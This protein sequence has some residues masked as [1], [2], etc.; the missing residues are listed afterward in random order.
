MSSRHGNISSYRVKKSILHLI[1]HCMK[2]F[3]S[4]RQYNLSCPF[5]SSHFVCCHFWHHTFG[6]IHASYLFLKGKIKL[7]LSPHKFTV[8]FNLKWMLLLQVP[9][10]LS[11]RF[12]LQILNKIFWVWWHYS[13][14]TCQISLLL[15]CLVMSGRRF[16]VS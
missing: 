8:A 1:T 4:T 6:L 11:N 2:Q 16:V 7:D 5:C 3:V 15:C 9:K 12:I 10:L 14:T 13:A